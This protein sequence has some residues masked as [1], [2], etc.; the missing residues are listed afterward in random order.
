MRPHLQRNG[1]L[2]KDLSLREHMGGF[3]TIKESSTK[4]FAPL[5]ARTRLLK[6]TT[7]IKVRNSTG[8]VQITRPTQSEGRGL[9]CF[10][11]NVANNSSQ[12]QRQTPPADV[13]W[14]Q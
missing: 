13:D 3:E 4:H 11:S 9:V 8:F 2:Q 10:I 1:E 5:L 12:R 14:L 6:M 7:A